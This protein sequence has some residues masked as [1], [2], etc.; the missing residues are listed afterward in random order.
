MAE[1]T[2]NKENIKNIFDFTNEIVKNYPGRIIG[3]ENCKKAA[4]RIKDELAGTLGAGR[5]KM[6]PFDAHP[7]S[8]IRG[9]Q[10]LGPMLMYIILAISFFVGWIHVG[11]LDLALM[12]NVGIAVFILLVATSQF[13]FYKHTF[14]NLFPT[15]HPGRPSRCPI[16]HVA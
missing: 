1:P 10:F 12:L 4:H 7:T 16:R 15:N 6:E 13:F 11:S 2:I 3:T 14:D 5:V 9:L 8:F